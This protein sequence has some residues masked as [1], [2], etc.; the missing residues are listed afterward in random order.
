MF[1]IASTLETHLTA[2][3]SPF[4][5]LTFE[6]IAHSA[7]V[8]RTRV[9]PTN[10]LYGSNYDTSPVGVT[11]NSAHPRWP[12]WP[13]CP[14]LPYY[15][16]TTQQQI[17]WLIALLLYFQCQI[18]TYGTIGYVP[19]VRHS[20]WPHLCIAF[21]TIWLDQCPFLCY[22]IAQISFSSVPH[23]LPVNFD[24]RIRRDPLNKD[25]GFGKLFTLNTL[26]H[27]VRNGINVQILTATSVTNTWR[28][29]ALQ[30]SRRIKL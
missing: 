6:M 13:S 18:F 10:D 29:F 12:P 27:L 14:C 17:T 20:F 25:L 8:M 3:H 9:E 11:S 26:W 2:D 5:H 28:R 19:R 1:S 23:E 30:V 15:I 7:K 4:S 16:Q 21:K 24:D 22:R